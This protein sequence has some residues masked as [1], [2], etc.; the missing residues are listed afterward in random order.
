MR[1]LLVNLPLCVLPYGLG[2]RHIL[3]PLWIRIFTTPVPVQATNTEFKSIDPAASGLSHSVVYEL[4][5]VI[6]AIADWMRRRE[7]KN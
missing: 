7:A 5:P 6:D 3:S 2:T 1:V 4:D